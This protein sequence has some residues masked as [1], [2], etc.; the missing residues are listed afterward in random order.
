MALYSVNQITAPAGSGEIAEAGRSDHST[1]GRQIIDLF[2]R[3]SVMPFFGRFTDSEKPFTESG[4]EVLSA[5]AGRKRRGKEVD[6]ADLQ[7]YQQMSYL[8]IKLCFLLT[9]IS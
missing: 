2:R 3:P 6:L 8:A 4:D 1:D 5:A 9:I 7:P